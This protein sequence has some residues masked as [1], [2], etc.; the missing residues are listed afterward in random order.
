M[1]LRSALHRQGLRFR[2]DLLIR[3]GG[4]RVRRDIVF[5]RLRLAAFMDG[6]FWHS[7]PEHGSMPKRHRDYWLP[8]LEANVKRDRRVDAALRASGWETLRVWEHVDPTEAAQFIQ[9]ELEALSASKS[10]SRTRGAT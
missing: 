7:C 8:T 4:V 10:E 6:C 2:K 9:Q 5:T 3:I 1:R